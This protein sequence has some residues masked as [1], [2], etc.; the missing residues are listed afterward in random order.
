MI[1]SPA[2]AAACLLVAAIITVAEILPRFAP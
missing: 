1:P 2:F